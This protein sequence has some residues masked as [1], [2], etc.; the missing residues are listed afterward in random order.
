[1]E[2]KVVNSIYKFIKTK[3]VKLFERFNF[4]YHNQKYQLKD[5]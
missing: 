4:K 1:M 3:H 5:I 2:S